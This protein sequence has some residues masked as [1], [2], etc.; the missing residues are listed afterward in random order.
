MTS[1]YSSKVNCANVFTRS[2]NSAV[3]SATSSAF[4]GKNGQE[5]VV[6]VAGNSRETAEAPKE[7]IGTIVER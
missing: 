5:E 1:N 2:G 6:V 4:G 7:D 3:E